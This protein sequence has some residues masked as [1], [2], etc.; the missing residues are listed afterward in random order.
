MDIYSE[1]TD[2]IMEQMEQGVIPWQK[3]WVACGKAISRTTG[4]PYSLLNQM[5]LGRP[6]EYL[7]FKQC[8]EAGGKVK[9]G[10][11]SQMVVFWKWI[12][13]E[14]EETGEKKEVPFLRY[15]NVFHIDQCEGIIAKHTTE[16]AFPDGAAAD[17]AAQGIIADYLNREKVRLSHQEGDRAFYRPATD[18]IVL[19]L[20]KQFNSTAEYYST[21]FHEIA[22][23]TGHEKRLNRL[24]KIAFFGF[25]AYSKEELIAE[26][27]A[28]ALVSHARLETD[29]SFRNNAAYIQNWLKV[30]KD[31]KRFIVSAAGKAEKA[32]SLIL[33][34]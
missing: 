17:E 29:R 30:L 26:I 27:G 6:G 22:H 21:A 25:D 20:M 28:A 8:Q 16:T 5:L 32:V 33:N 7:T 31:D 11:K 4:K 1:V 34:Q 18:E 19:P 24:E 12:E 3:P 15:Y 13:T 23:S 2:R 10:E 9:K 14:D